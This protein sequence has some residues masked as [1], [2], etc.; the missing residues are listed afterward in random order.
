MMR[1]SSIRIISDSF[2]KLNSFKSNFGIFK[3]K[4]ITD[5]SHFF[6]TWTYL[7]GSCYLEDTLTNCEHPQT[8]TQLNLA[9]AQKV[10]LGL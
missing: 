2:L 9:D 7:A 8:N 10:D 5:F 6:L 1:H 3:S 4:E